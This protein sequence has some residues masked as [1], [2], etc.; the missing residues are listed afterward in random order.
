MD[1]ILKLVIDEK[2]RDFKCFKMLKYYYETNPEFAAFI[3]EGI[4][5]GKVKGFSDYLWN[6][7]ASLNVRNPINFEEAFSEGYNIGNCTK[8][9]RYLSYCF[10]YPYICGGTLPLIKGSKNSEN[11][12]HTWVSNGGKIYDTSLVLIMDEAY[13]KQ[14]L[15]YNEENRYNPNASAVYSAGKEYATDRNLRH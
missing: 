15:H 8:F 4:L 14:R 1:E 12:K 7:M 13:A 9:S 2:R 5:S 10:S 6:K 11:G 3:K